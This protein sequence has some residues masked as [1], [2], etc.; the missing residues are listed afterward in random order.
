MYQNSLTEMESDVLAIKSQQHVLFEENKALRKERDNLARRLQEE[1]REAEMV[2]EALEAE[3]TTQALKNDTLEK[4]I[5]KIEADHRMR[6]QM[7][8]IESA[9][10]LKAMESNVAEYEQ[11][12][13]AI[14]MDAAQF[15][16]PKKQ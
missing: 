10:K 4:E 15:V 6:M 13:D 9:Q 12:L 16:T 11:R 5:Q 3:V 1:S 8:E 2:N 7:Q 14:R